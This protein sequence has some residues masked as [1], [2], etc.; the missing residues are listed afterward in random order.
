MRSLLQ[1]KM[2]WIQSIVGGAVAGVVS[3][4]SRRCK[5]ITMGV[6]DVLRVQCQ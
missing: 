2:Q 5:Q 3:G 1:L 6:A 4:R